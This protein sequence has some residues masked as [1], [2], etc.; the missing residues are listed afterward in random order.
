VENCGSKV[1]EAIRGMSP[2]TVPAVIDAMGEAIGDVTPAD[3][4]GWFSHCGYYI[5]TSRAPL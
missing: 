5:D 2:R 1:K 4:R 3:A